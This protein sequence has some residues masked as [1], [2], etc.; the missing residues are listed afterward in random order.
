MHN[1]ACCYITCNCQS[2]LSICSFAFPFIDWWWVQA[3]FCTGHNQKEEMES[4]KKGSQEGSL[5][6]LL[7]YQPAPMSWEFLS[8]KHLSAW[9]ELSCNLSGFLLLLL[10]LLFLVLSAYCYQL[11]SLHP[12]AHVL[13]QSY[14]PMDCSP[15]GSSVLG[16]LEYW[17]WLPF[18]PPLSVVLNPLVHHSK[19]LLQQD[20]KW[21]REINRPENCM[22]SRH[23]G[24]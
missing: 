17:S 18:P 20:K 3:L 8:N 13:A 10:L 24:E 1:R 21:G 5:G 7:W 4:T 19:F 2:A 16:L 12:H 11:I 14:N 6:W 23:K 9:G 22:D 15:P